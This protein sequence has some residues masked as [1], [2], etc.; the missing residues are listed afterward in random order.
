MPETVDARDQRGHDEFPGP[1]T[2]ARPLSEFPCLQPELLL[3]LRERAQPQRVELDE[4]SRVAVII[5]DRAFL[6][7]DELLVVE[8][9]AALTP[10][11]DGTALVELERHTPRDIAL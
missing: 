7:G 3:S 9:I 8:R 4:T 1:A 2:E 11:H 10:D 5:G 6:E